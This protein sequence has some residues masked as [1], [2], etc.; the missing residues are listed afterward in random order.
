MAAFAPFIFTVFYCNVWRTDH[1]DN[2][3]V[4]EFNLHWCNSNL[5]I[6]AEQNL[7]SISCSN[8]LSPM[9]NVDIPLL[10]MFHS[11]RVCDISVF[12]CS[13][14]VFSGS[15]YRPDISNWLRVK[16]FLLSVKSILATRWTIYLV[17]WSGQ[18]EIIE[19][20]IENVNRLERKKGLWT[21]KAIC[22]LGQVRWHSL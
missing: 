4:K 12:C 19:F 1:F 18:S 20:V 3:T 9:G 21:H 16:C 6:A 15:I 13:C 22:S 14:K 5:R 11:N 2:L 10:S 17:E 7:F 8:S